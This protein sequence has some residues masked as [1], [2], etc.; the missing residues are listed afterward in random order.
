[1]SGAVRRD[2][3]KKGERMF[4]FGA[5]PPEVTSAKMYT[6][7]GSGP[8]MGAA[9]AW[10][11]L[12]AEL[13]SFAQG[14]SSV[15]SA[16]QGESWT[17]PAAT[18]MAAAATPYAQ[19]AATTAAQAEQAA[20]QARGSAAAYETA[21]AA[22]VPP[23]V[24]AANRTQLAHLIST[25]LLGQNTAQIGAT[26]AHYAQMWAQNTQAMYGYATS[27]SSATQLS[28]FTAPPPTTNPAG[29][30]A[31]PAAAA[32]AAGSSGATHM[33]TL[34]QLLSS[35]PQQLS[36]AAAPSS[37]ASSGASSL[38]GMPMSQPL[39][40]SIGNLNTLDGPLG[41][42]MAAARTMGNI[43]TFSIA[44]YRFMAD[45]ALYAPLIGLS[46]AASPMAG[47]AGVTSAAS[48]ATASASPA[49]LASAGTAAPVGPLSVPPAWA[50]ATPVAAAHEVP[51]W[52]SE[53]EALW[54]AD[55]AESMAGG[56]PT[57]GVGPMAGVAGA[58]AAGMLAR[59]VVSNMLRVAPRRFKMPRSKSGG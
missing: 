52:M 17:G 46:G 21:H 41:F 44:G 38:F 47:L 25:N 33:Q 49:V 1:M 50:H 45:A 43:G 29:A 31:A 42:A 51:L 34:S 24:V 59:P 19:W 13:N 48:A 12:A 22:V 53:A 58:A 23:P 55:P 30:S 26:E 11:G 20:S 27:A 7:P 10:N 32:A 18:A 57:A 14:Y 37:A 16:L 15:I 56:G 54:E 36:A 5:L 6:G 2:P 4:D 40:D 28:P 3:L 9:A 39:L 8:M 35:V